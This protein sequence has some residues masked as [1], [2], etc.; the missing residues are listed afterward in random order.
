MFGCLPWTRTDGRR[1]AMD[2]CMKRPSVNRD[3]LVRPLPQP[4]SRGDLQH[5][6]QVVQERVHALRDIEPPRRRAERGKLRLE[7]PI[8]G[9]RAP[10]AAAL[11][12]GA[13]A[14]ALLLVA[15]KVVSAAG[16][17]GSASASP[18]PPSYWQ[19]RAREWAFRTG[20]H[21]CCRSRGTPASGTYGQG[22]ALDSR[23]RWPHLPRPPRRGGR[24]RRHASS[25]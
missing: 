3:R 5:V 4:R 23:L 2:G 16:L 12:R 19:G 20:R 11:A 8:D 22:P 1:T 15:A 9:E 10:L 18:T 24:H 21:T 13:G 14:S 25:S 6:P 17:G 7:A